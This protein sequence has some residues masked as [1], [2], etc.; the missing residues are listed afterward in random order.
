MHFIPRGILNN[1]HV[2]TLQL[3]NESLSISF[4]NFLQVVPFYTHTYTL[5]P[6]LF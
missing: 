2:K 4:S 3:L 6:S 1:P 5:I